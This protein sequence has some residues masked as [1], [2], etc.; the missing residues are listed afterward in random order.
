[1]KRT[2][3]KRKTPLK[4]GDK[5]LKRTGGPKP[6]S[7][8]RAVENRQRATVREQLRAERPHCEFPGCK[9]PWVDMHEVKKRSRGGSI[10]DKSNI[11]C[12][13]REHHEFTEAEPA[14]ATEMGLL[15]PSWEE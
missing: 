1:M 8:K 6:V 13:C 9:A 11:L 4:Q 7:K 2:P 3:L 14:K 15:K 10:T 12:L 5:Q